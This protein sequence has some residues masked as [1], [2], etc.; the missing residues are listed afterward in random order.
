MSRYTAKLDPATMPEKAKAYC[1]AAVH[2]LHLIEDSVEIHAAFG[3]DI[4]CQG[5]F[6]Q[7]WITGMD[8]EDVESE[9]IYFPGGL[10]G[11]GMMTSRNTILNQLQAFDLDETFKATWPEH[12]QAMML[13]LPF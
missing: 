5:Y 1:A 10:D 2:I 11:M 13:D 7:V 3:Y 4:P 8:E 6:A 12:W 9:D